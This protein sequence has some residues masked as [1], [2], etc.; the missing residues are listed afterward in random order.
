M[1]QV[2]VT[3]LTNIENCLLTTR[4]AL[5][6]KHNGI[7]VT[8]LWNDCATLGSQSYNQSS[9]R[10]HGLLLGHESLRTSNWG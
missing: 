3:W 1:V 5:E 2:A 10:Y 6:W 8:L 4:C 9:H 7:E